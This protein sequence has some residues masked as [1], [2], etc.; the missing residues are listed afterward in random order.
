MFAFI[1]PG[2][3]GLSWSFRRIGCALD[4]LQLLSITCPI[5]LLRFF[6]RSDLLGGIASGA[7][8]LLALMM[9]GPSSS[10]LDDISASEPFL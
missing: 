3:E 10:S 9:T 6:V 8:L 1:F 5:T 2:I 7:V 4:V